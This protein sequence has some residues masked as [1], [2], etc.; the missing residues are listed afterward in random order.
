MDLVV[1]TAQVAA[2]VYNAI[3]AGWRLAKAN[4]ANGYLE[5]GAVHL[6]EAFKVMEDGRGETLT[7]EES[8]GYVEKYERYYTFQS[9]AC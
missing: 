9:R 3:G 6:K 1:P 8:S 5:R 4:T 2:G 7:S